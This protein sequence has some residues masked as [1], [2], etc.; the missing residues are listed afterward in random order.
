M[1]LDLSLPGVSGFAVRQELGAHAH[2]RN[3]PIVIVT[4]SGENLDHLHVAC[5]LRKPASPD[6]L[7]NSVRKCLASVAFIG[8][9]GMGV[10][11]SGLRWL[12][13]DKTRL[14][15]ACPT[16]DYSKLADPAVASAVEFSRVHHYQVLLKYVMRPCAGICCLVV[17]S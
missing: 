1:V 9:I 8:S 11:I 13:L 17:D 15:P 5:L 12:V 4:G 10:F 7:L 3:I 14:M 2:T 6:D 16:F